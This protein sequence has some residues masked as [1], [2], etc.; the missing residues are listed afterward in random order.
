MTEREHYLGFTLVSGIGP[1][2]FASLLTIFKTAKNIWEAS[3]IELKAA[4]LGPISTQKFINF[5]KEFDFGSYARKLEKAGVGFVALCDKNYPKLLKALDDA[6]IVLFTRGDFSLVNFE[7]T[8]GVVGTRKITNYGREVTNLF[9]TDLAM[10]GFTIVLGLAMGV[11]AV[12]G[13]SAIAAGG[14]TVAVLGSGIDLCYP[15]VNKPLY[16]KIIKDGGVVVSEFPM[17]LEPNPGTFPSRNRII[18]GLS[19]GVLVTEGAE[20]SG[21]LITANVALAINRPAFAI[22]GPITSSLSKAPLKL[23]AKGGKLVT[24][25]EDIQKE[26][27]I[28][29]YELRMKKTDTKFHNLSKDELKIVQLLENEGLSFDEI[30]RNSK[31]DSSAVGSL[32]SMMEI[33]GILRNCDGLFQLAA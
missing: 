31:L 26:L 28:K 30:V 16:D 19:L 10:N 14:K 9:A 20:D 13:W 29:N 11:D 2:R 17:G 5:K 18:A 32:L 22:P 23:I 25:A 24:S 7:R 15:P 33:K 3:E 12:A 8:I 27:G 6:P 21:S 4:G 1:K